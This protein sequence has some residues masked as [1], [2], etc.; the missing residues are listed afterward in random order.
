MP[1]KDEIEEASGLVKEEIALAS[2]SLASL[3]DITKNFQHTTTKLKFKIVDVRGNKCYTIFW[4]H[5]LTRDF[6]RSLIHRGSTRVDGIFNFTIIK[7]LLTF[8]T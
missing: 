8:N 4:G 3:Y 2:I 6:I 5:E 1:N 7:C